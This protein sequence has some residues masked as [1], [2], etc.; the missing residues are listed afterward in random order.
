MRLSFSK[1]QPVE[2]PINITLASQSVG[3]KMLLDK[4]GIR[5]RVV[6][7][8][9]EEE[10]IVDP[11]PLVMIR[12]RAAA[13]VDEV[14]TNPR[15]YGIATEEKSLVIA[16]DS[17]AIMGK[18]VYGKSKNKDGAK[19]MLRK[20]MGRTHTFA[21][22]VNVVYVVGAVEKR[23]FAKIIKTRVTMRK[24]TPAEME[25]YVT[26]YDFTRF[27]AA[28]AINEAPWHLVTRIDGSYTNVIGLPFEVLIPILRNLK[29][30]V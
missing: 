30:I 26:K 13:K 22:A 4:L 18:E 21:T 17:M 7:A 6:V 12:R 24:M 29:I 25:S 5:F 23:R 20:L 27:A 15:V 2:K 10:E 28:Y 1:G 3:R 14:V 16:A 19:D 8:H 11:D 9:V